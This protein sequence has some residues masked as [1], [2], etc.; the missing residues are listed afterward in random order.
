MRASCVLT[1]KRAPLAGL[2][3]TLATPLLAAVDT[4]RPTPKKEK[5]YE[6]IMY[7]ILRRYDIFLGL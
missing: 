5:A 4:G 2:T 3:I 7:Y 1:N 6:Q